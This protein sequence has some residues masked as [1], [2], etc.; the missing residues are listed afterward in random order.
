MGAADI[1]IVL[2]GTSHAKHLS[3]AVWELIRNGHYWGK[4]DVLVIFFS[5]SRLL[6]MSLDGL[7]FDVNGAIPLL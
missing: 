6:F 3:I 5:I 2:V 4:V 7:S 1:Q